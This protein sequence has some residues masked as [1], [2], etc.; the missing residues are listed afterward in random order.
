MV[1]FMSRILRHIQ[2]RARALRP[3]ATAALTLVCA[4]A[5][6]N[7]GAMDEVYNMLPQPNVDELVDMQGLMSL[8]KMPDGVHAAA[9]SYEY[10]GGNLIAR[11]HV[12]L[13]APDKKI[14]ADKLILNNDTMDFEVSGD[15]TFSALM[16]TRTLMTLEQYNATRSDPLV[17]VE[18][19]GYETAPD[20]TQKLYVEKTVTTTLIRASRAAGNWKSGTM[21]FRNFALKSGMIF[22]T[23]KFA[24]RSFD[25][26]IDVK[27]AKFTTCEYLVD[28]H[29]HYA[30]ASYDAVIYPRPTNSSLYQYQADDGEHTIWFFNNFIEVYGLPVF[31]LPVLYKPADI[32]SFGAKLEFGERSRWGYYVRTSKH[33]KLLD[34]PYLNTNLMFDFYERRGP[35]FGMSADL[36]TPESA[37]EFFL[38]GMYD[39]NP[40]MYFDYDWDSSQPNSDYRENN[41][42]MTIPNM[43]YEFRFNN[44]THLTSRLDFRGQV[45]IL[46]DYNFL[47]DFFNR[48][49]NSELEPPTYASLEYQADRFTASVYTTVRVNDF[50][51]TVQRLPEIRLDFQRQELFAN[52]YYQGE[53]SLTPLSMQWRRFGRSDEEV[54]NA[55]GSRRWRD[56]N[57]YDYKTLRFDTLHMFYYPL[58]FWNINFIP[59]TGFRLTA[60]SNTS[61]TDVSLEDLTTMFYVDEVD[62]IP[63]ESIVRNYDD[64]G[65][66]KLRFAAEIGFELNTKFYRAWQDV[67]NAY[68][69]LD[70]LRHVIVPYLNYTFIPQPTVSEEK[71]YYFDE[72]D[73]ITEQNFVRL[74]M[75]NRL[76]TRRNGEIY[77]WLSLEH[78]WDF[79]F[80]RAYG[81]NHIGDFGT[82]LRF[83]PTDKLTFT[84]ELLLD[85][86]RNNAHEYQVV[87]GGRDRGRPGLDSP[88]IN[89]WYNEISYEFAPDWRI[90]AYYRYADSYTQRNP[91]SMGSMFTVI[92]VSSMPYSPSPQRS[93]VIGSGLSFPFMFD[94][95]LFGRV[96]VAYDIDRNLIDNLSFAIIK[97]FHC[98]YFS[99]SFGMEQDWESE[100]GRVR[101]RN[102]NYIT[103]AVSLVAM[104]SLSFGA[105]SEVD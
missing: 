58:K 82:I 43:R 32:S 14:T 49:Y 29:S 66:A 47:R 21:Q 33:F 57:L 101:R 27:K 88:L 75:I 95:D 7:E 73:R 35:G 83:S 31:W 6:A 91:Y 18:I 102:R 23:G 55:F 26:T 64:K 85:V 67:R 56:W 1:S 37:S 52:L 80:H 92:D 40:Y 97:K 3:L 79:F 69:Q 76:Q 81:F 105:R 61:R 99:T 44:V 96:Q 42:R 65:G 5:V 11:G 30:I 68:W 28:N 54:G 16:K 84:S 2:N 46:S 100:D 78:F 17:S 15:V 70:G 50:F 25:G 12:V 86:G 90:S 20:G 63:S 24:E 8:G 48:R 51:T 13:T 41:S 34:E 45:D 77:E 103:F 38:Y 36:V 104:P 53:T 72:I 19:L 22:C 89:R 39:R 71:L 59:R 4:H 9:D 87:S 10:V 93:Q 60:Y 62:G 94:K 98:W 74:G